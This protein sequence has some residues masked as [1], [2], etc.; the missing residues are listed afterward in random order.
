[1]LT[2]GEVTV[3]CR[4][5]ECELEK[6]WHIR[7]SLPFRA[8]H[9]A[10]IQWHT[11]QMVNFYRLGVKAILF[12][13]GNLQRGRKSMS[14]KAIKVRSPKLLTHL[15]ANFSFCKLGKD[16]PH[17]GV[18]NEKIN[19][20]AAGPYRCYQFGCLF[21]RWQIFGVWKCWSDY[22]HLGVINGEISQTATRSYRCGHFSYLFAWREVLSVWKLKS[23]ATG[24]YRCSH[25]SY[26]FA[27][28]KLLESGSWDK[29]IRI[30][31]STTGI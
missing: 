9:K 28:W 2:W 30:W 17:L 23:T 27:W 11:R 25:F 19:P 3:G 4:T 6:Y 7:A 31:E 8:I 13:Y 5:L 21:A 24:P 26:L 12:G 15:M 18:F 1:M 29:T 16:Y 20:D 14:Y 10:S 22:T